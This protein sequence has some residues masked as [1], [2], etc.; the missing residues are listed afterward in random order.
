M[1]GV[2]AGVTCLGGSALFAS[3]AATRGLAR[4]ETVEAVEQLFVF[5]AQGLEV[6]PELLYLVGL[7]TLTADR[8]DDLFNT[9]LDAAIEIT[10]A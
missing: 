6:V 4:F 9:T 5:L 1:T 8:F 10:G 3:C 2:S 7:F